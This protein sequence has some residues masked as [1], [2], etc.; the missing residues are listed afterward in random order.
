MANTTFDKSSNKAST[1][2]TPPLSGRQYEIAYGNQRAVIAEVGATLRRYDV[3]G[4]PIIDGFG[5]DEICHSA[6]GQVLAPWPN[7]LRD[8]KYTF[9]GKAATVAINEPERHNA[10]HGLLRYHLW[11]LVTATQNYCRLQCIL[12]P[13]PAYPWWLEIQIEYRLSRSGLSVEVTASTPGKETAPFG[14]GF[15][16]YLS[17]NRQHLDGCRIM[18]PASTVLV[19]DD[20]MIPADQHDVTGSQ[21]DIRT[22]TLIGDTSLDTAYTGLQRDADGIAKV[23]L[24]P[25]D[26]SRQIT[27]WMDSSFKYVQV[28]TADTLPD[29][30]E[31][32]RMIALEPM[33]CPPNALQTH[34][35]IIEL[36]PGQ[37]FHAKWGIS[38]TALN[39]NPN[40]STVAAPAS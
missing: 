6:K 22:P 37:R 1:E 15:H 23:E 36:E 35:D 25:A 20:R 12:A 33:T 5:E 10:I 39:D 13:Q 29:E 24:D 19:I 21:Y 8:G 32:R 14:I 26:G 30:S 31:R 3:G 38:T 18:V 7:R 16:P 28:F 17:T 2:V 34:V 27:L 11:N 4:A 40:H 9:K